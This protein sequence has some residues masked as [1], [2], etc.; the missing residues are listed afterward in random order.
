[1]MRGSRPP[2]ARTTLSRREVGRAFVG[3]AL[4]LGCSPSTTAC[5]PRSST[6]RD[7]FD[8]LFFGH[9]DRAI[10]IGKAYLDAYGEPVVPGQL[11]VVAEPAARILV[12]QSTLEA[13]ATMFDEAVADDFAMHDVVVVEGWVLARHEAS[14]CA[15]AYAESRRA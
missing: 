2:R 14:L 12:E 8:V 11:P 1:M 5:A 4:L 9:R 13:A 7:D 10:R 3:V 6:E 15:L